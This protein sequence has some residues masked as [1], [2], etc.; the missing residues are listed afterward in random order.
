M[1]AT[2]TS[3]GPPPLAQIIIP[4]KKHHY[5]VDS[6]ENQQSAEKRQKLMIDGY[7]MSANSSCSLRPSE[8]EVNSLKFIGLSTLFNNIYEN[9]ATL[10]K[11]AFCNG[12]QRVKQ[13]ATGQEYALKVLSAQSV[14]SHPKLL[15]SMKQEFY[16]GRWLEHPGLPS[17]YQLIN[18]TW[19]HPRTH[20]LT[21]FS[22]LLMEYRTGI[23]LEELPKQENYNPMEH[24]FSITSQILE[25]VSYLHGS[26]VVHR[27]LKPDNCL[28][29][30]A[31]NK[32]TIIDLGLS[33]YYDRD[34]SIQMKRKNGTGT[35][36]CM[37]PEEL[38]LLDTTS[39]MLPLID[40]WSIGII[41]FFLLFG[42]T[43]FEEA[44]DIA[45]LRK[46]V[47]DFQS[48]DIQYPNNVPLELQ[49][50]IWKFLIQD[51]KKRYTVT[52]VKEYWERTL[53]PLIS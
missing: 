27:D 43:P 35:P 10:G 37:S 47:A 8:Q 45:E 25:T 48:H 4:G 26:S 16:I 39:Q 38:N 17:Y 13:K 18:F 22:G 41:L 7:E 6:A 42:K 53:Y 51:P 12:V 52:S 9:V 23:I 50:V 46:M 34:S 1:A 3:L 31:T 32:L 28:F 11:G 44:K 33:C 21:N 49:A 40:S 20:N 2:G 30:K 29:D 15:T 19:E 5:S 14:R 24:I 36:L